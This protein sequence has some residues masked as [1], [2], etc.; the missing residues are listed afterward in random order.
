MIEPV[1][2]RPSENVRR[3]D[4]AVHATSDERRHGC[5]A[6]IEEY[7]E[8]L[9]EARGDSAARSIG[10]ALRALDQLASELTMRVRDCEGQVERME[11]EMVRILT[12]QTVLRVLA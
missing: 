3:A 2:G 7:V 6:P 12:A 1:T 11:T 4:E 9:R 10:E 8:V 5:P